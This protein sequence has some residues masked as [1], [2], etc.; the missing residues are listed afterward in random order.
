MIHHGGLAWQGGVVTGMAAALIFMRVKNLPV[1]KTL[2]IV[3]PYIALGQSIGRVGCFLNGCC[4]GKPLSWGIYFPVHQAH[5]HPA[6]L[7]DALGLLVLFFVLKEL[8]RLKKFDGQIFILYVIAASL[9]RFVVE[10]FRADH[11]LIG[12]TLSIFQI[13]TLGFMSLATY[14]YLYLKS[15]RRQ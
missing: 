1:R 9:L 5:L 2:D 13:M 14:A 4:Y 6:Q 7:Y 3:A 8:L 11:T 15:R 12:E 10:F